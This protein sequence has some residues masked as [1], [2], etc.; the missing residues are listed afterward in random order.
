MATRYTAIAT[1]ALIA[2]AAGTS[3]YTAST[4]QQAREAIVAA[5]DPTTRHGELAVRVD[6]GGADVTALAPVEP[7]TAGQVL[8][9]SD[10]GL[11]VWRA[12]ATGGGATFSGTGFAV[13]AA[14]DAGTLTASSTSAADL[15]TA[16]GAA[17]GMDSFTAYSAADFT[18]VN[19][20]G[21][22]TATLTSGMIRYVH[23]NAA[24]RY[25]S[26][27]TRDAPR[28]KLAIPSG[29]AR[30]VVA[31]RV[32]TLTTPGTTWDA[33]GIYLRDTADETA[34]PAAIVQESPTYAL[35]MASVVH[36]R[37]TGARVYSGEAATSSYSGF[38]QYA[39]QTWDGTRWIAL[40]W[41]AQTGVVM[42]GLYI[43]SGTPTSPDQFVWANTG[44]GAVQTLGCARPAWAVVAALQPG[45][46]PTAMQ[47]DAS[48]LAW[49][50]GS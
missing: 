14:G 1:A 42:A 18:T 6:A 34:A 32:T 43:S 3:L 5:H 23:T 25:Y 46:T 37:D 26:A 33:L 49:R 28:A 21:G 10:A 9:V 22:D 47:F 7:G 40:Q 41:D 24:A 44:A 38:S 30:L 15:R 36:F 45:G 17:T 16:L 11:P 20:G 39:S 50:W 27:A 19:G 8:T 29:T 31:A 2:G 13:V 35:R 4:A 48:I 12:A